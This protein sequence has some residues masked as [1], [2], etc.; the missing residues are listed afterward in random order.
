[1]KPNELIDNMVEK[2]KAEVKPTI[3]QKPAAPKIPDNLNPKNPRYKGFSR[4]DITNAQLVEDGDEF[5][6]FDTKQKRK[7]SVIKYIPY[8]SLEDGDNRELYGVVNNFDGS[9]TFKGGAIVSHSPES[10]RYDLER[11]TQL[12]I[13]GADRYLKRGKY[14]EEFF[15]IVK[16]SREKGDDEH[17]KQLYGWDF[18][19]PFAE[20]D[21]MKNDPYQKYLLSKQNKTPV[22]PQ[23][24][25]FEGLKDDEI[26]EALS[27]YTWQITEGTTAWDY[28]KSVAEKIKADPKRVFEII[29]MQAPTE[30]NENSNMEKLVYAWEN[31]IPYKEP[32][33]QSH[34]DALAFA[35]SKGYSGLNDPEYERAYGP[36]RHG[37]ETVHDLNTGGNVMWYSGKTDD[38]RFYYVNE[39]TGDLYYTNKDITNLLPQM[40]NSRNPNAFFNKNIK[41][42]VTERHTDFDNTVESLLDEIYAYGRKKS[43]QIG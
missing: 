13:Q 42:F 18:N 34:A 24:P 7:L 27:D 32:K 15:N 8:G 11:Q 40:L 2:S 6:D 16:D 43:K 26:S 21:F 37:I 1:M 4:S 23:A 38:G 35:K 17:Y 12:G 28:A 9:D 33:K 36:Y 22:P 5:D 31:D 39:M 20:H 3:P 19:K 10:A 29:K 41:P 14:D 30:I 25:K